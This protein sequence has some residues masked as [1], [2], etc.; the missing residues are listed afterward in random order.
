MSTG[1]DVLIEVAARERDLRAI[2]SDGATA[3]SV[4]DAR[5]VFGLHP[6]LPVGWTLY[7]AGQVL[8]GS[9]PGEPLKDLVSRVSPTPLFL[10]ATGKGVDGE[11]EANH[12]YA[13]AAKQPFEFWDLPEV[14][15]TAAIREKAPEYEDRVVGFFDQAL[16]SG[17]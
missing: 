8:S 11:R 12:V 1:A 9:T 4:A 10:I 13:A 15:H 5:N 14:H 17:R 3:R 16:L 2:V 7:T 6:T